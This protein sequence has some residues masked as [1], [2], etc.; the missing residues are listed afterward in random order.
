[1]D[2]RSN[3]ATSATI[4]EKINVRQYRLHFR[5]H[6]FTFSD[7]YFLIRYLR[8]CIVP[9]CDEKK[10]H[11][12]LTRHGCLLVHQFLF[13]IYQLSLVVHIVASQYF[14]AASHGPSIAAKRSRFLCCLSW[15][16]E[17]LSRFFSCFSRKFLPSLFYNLS[18]IASFSLYHSFPSLSIASYGSS[19]LIGVYPLSHL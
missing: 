8:H 7:I 6:Y 12:L 14:S 16:F 1:M 13:R 19:I 3:P 5:P 10:A 15:F 4:W 17:C 9:S 2:F 11:L 18:I